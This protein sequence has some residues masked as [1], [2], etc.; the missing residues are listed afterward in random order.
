M[1]GRADQSISRSVT[2]TAMLDKPLVLEPMQFN[3]DG[4]VAYTLKEIEKGRRFQ[5]TFTNILVQPGL[6]RG[7]LKI[8]TNYP[9]KPVITMQITGR[10]VE[11]RKAAP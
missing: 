9:E 11:A 8:K 10:F 3:L 5:I 4:K 7:L 2:V 1:Q 6:Y